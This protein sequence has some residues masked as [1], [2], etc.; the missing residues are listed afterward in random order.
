MDPSLVGFMLEVFSGTY[1]VEA[2]QDYDL[3]V[4]EATDALSDLLEAL[5]VGGYAQRA[6]VFPPYH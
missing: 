5:E 3:S 6:E 4:D 2:A 1:F